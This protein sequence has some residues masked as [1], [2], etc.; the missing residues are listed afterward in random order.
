MQVRVKHILYVNNDEWMCL[1]YLSNIQ[2][3]NKVNNKNLASVNRF[4][5]IFALFHET[6]VG[7]S[8]DLID[9]KGR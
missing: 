4:Y 7:L 1:L 2:N 9:W 6:D 3:K 5:S 8:F